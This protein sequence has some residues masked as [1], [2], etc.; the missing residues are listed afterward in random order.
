MALIPYSALS[1]LISLG[2]TVWIYTLVIGQSSLSGGVLVDG[3]EIA[4][5]LLY[6]STSFPN[7]YMVNETGNSC[8]GPFDCADKMCSAYYHSPKIKY[9][10]FRPHMPINHDT[11]CTSDMWNIKSSKHYTVSHTI[12]IIAF[13]IMAIVNLIN[14]AIFIHYYCSLDSGY[15]YIGN[16]PKNKK[17]RIACFLMNILGRLPALISLFVYL[18]YSSPYLVHDQLSWRSRVQSITACVEFSLIYIMEGILTSVYTS[19]LLEHTLN[20]GLSIRNK[21]IY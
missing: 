20:F 7:T 5:V 4:T 14:G 9:I 12:A 8:R 2:Y 19:I 18:F 21:I 16:V 17:I 13:I 6:N 1:V 15:E 11:K 10:A 3:G